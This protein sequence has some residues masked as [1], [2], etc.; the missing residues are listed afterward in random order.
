M[1]APVDG[2]A[3]SLWR[4]VTFPVRVLRPLVVIARMR[5]TGRYWAETTVVVPADGPTVHVSARPDIQEPRDGTGPLNHRRYRVRISD[6]RI[7][8]A[9]LLDVFRRDPN[10]FAPTSYATFAPDPS[11][12]GFREG[13]SITVTLPG[14]WNGP[15]A[16]ASIGD[17]AIRFETRTGHMEAGWIE[18]RSFDTASG[19]M[20]TFEIESFARSGDP[21]FDAL[22]HQVGIAK[23]VQSLMWVQTLE[24][25]VSISG[26]EQ[27]G[28]I[29][30]ETTTY[31][32]PRNDG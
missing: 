9:A 13:D 2:F 11:P 3:G 22:Y 10:A 15:V 19:D 18:F 26:G 30:I 5:L 1:K 20:M 21:L 24:S 14:P 4:S 7:T 29:C 27:V 32:G 8:P 6:P 16:I 12:A 31:R 28:K 23:L 25:A 17:H